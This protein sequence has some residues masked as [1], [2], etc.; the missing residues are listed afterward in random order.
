M[1]IYTPDEITILEAISDKI[2]RG[3]PVGMHEAVAAIDYQ[4]WL[5][6]QKHEPFERQPFAWVEHP[7]FLIAMIIVAL[8]VLAFAING[9]LS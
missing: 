8:I 9:N 1:S 3:E 4:Q 7:A 6:E 2:R 5:R